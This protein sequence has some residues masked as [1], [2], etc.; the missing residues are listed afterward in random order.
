M[1]RGVSVRDVSEGVC[2]GVIVR[3]MSLSMREYEYEEGHMLEIW[4]L[5]KLL[6]TYLLL[7]I[8]RHS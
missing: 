3:A 1:S 7:Y 6:M 5:S 4:E 8:C 2:D